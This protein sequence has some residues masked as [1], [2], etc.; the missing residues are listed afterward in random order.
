MSRKYKFTLLLWAIELLK[1]KIRGTLSQI[2]LD[3]GLDS[4]R[5]DFKQTQF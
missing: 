1:I 5:F 4:I 3:T 2:S